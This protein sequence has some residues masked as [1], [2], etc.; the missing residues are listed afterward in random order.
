MSERKLEHE[1]KRERRKAKRPPRSD[2]SI[3]MWMVVFL[4]ILGYRGI[5]AAMDQVP[6]PTEDPARAL[7]VNAALGRAVNFRRRLLT[8]VTQ[9]LQGSE[10]AGDEVFNEVPP[11]LRKLSEGWRKVKLITTPGPDHFVLATS[12]SPSPEN[13]P[14]RSIYAILTAAAS[15]ALVQL[16]L[17]GDDPLDSLP[18]RGGIDIAP[19]AYI[20]PEN[21]LYSPAVVSAY[22]L[23]SHEA[24]YPRIVAGK[25]VRSFLQAVI[26]NPNTD[27]ESNYAR[28]LAERVNGMLFQDSDGKLALDFYGPVIRDTLGDE[29]SR[30]IGRRA[31]AYAQKALAVHRASGNT[32]LIAKYERLVEYMGP[33]VAL[34][35]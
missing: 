8:S 16:A 31:W 32:K 18:L 29:P 11:H 20:A 28:I 1:R 25:R 15:A 33:R 10:T 13:F 5:L 7:A 2:E 34:W 21:I 9:F 3:T 27:L 22:E 6:L 30:T 23:E 35:S 19:G 4:D 26:Q 24:D 12:L 14:L 17:G